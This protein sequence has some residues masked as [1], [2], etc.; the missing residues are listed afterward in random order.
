MREP[1]GCPR[2]GASAVGDGPLGLPERRCLQEVVR[3]LGQV[4]LGVRSVELLDRLP[5]L[6][7]DDRATGR[8]DLR[9]ERLANERV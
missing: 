4:A 1:V 3:E 9:L 2:G 7:V 5:D 8:G 6:P